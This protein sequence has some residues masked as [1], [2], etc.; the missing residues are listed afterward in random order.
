MQFNGRAHRSTCADSDHSRNIREFQASDP[1]CNPPIVR[2]FLLQY[3]VCDSLLLFQIYYYRWKNP[4]AD[5]PITREIDPSEHSPLL[6]NPI[7]PKSRRRSCIDNEVV[8]CT[9]YLTFVIVA[10]ILASILD[11]KIRG[12][13]I[14]NE[15]EGVVE[16]KSQI[17]GWVSAAM[18]RTSSA[19]FNF[20]VYFAHSRLRTSGRSTTTNR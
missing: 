16:W 10:G 13:R 6:E 12:P 1:S 2:N 8:K 17:L 5:E 14:P 18:F 20:V 19:V 9:L 3:V 15:P 4:R 7:K 11:S